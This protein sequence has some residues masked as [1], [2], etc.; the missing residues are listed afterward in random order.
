MSSNVGDRIIVESEK[1][2]V[3]TREGEILEVIPHE[4]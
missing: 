3:P 4:T 2:G 1:V